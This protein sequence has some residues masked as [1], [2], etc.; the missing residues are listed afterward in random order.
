MYALERYRTVHINYYGFSKN[1]ICIYFLILGRN[2]CIQD[3]FK[4]NNVKNRANEPT[5]SPPQIKLSYEFLYLPW[6]I[7][8][9][10]VK[11]INR[12]HLT[13]LTLSA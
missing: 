6:R 12:Y 5:P 10:R 4:Y 8:F 3:T 13:L 7:I 11:G 9:L 1:L 2:I